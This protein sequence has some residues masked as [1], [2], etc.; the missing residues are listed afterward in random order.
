MHPFYVCLFDIS[1]VVQLWHLSPDT[2]T[3]SAASSSLSPVRTFWAHSMAVLS[4]DWSEGEAHS[5]L[6]GCL[7]GAVRWWDVK[8]TRS[9]LL[10]LAGMLSSLSLSSFSF[11]L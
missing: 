1:G 2:D 3:D 8:D 6:T 7:N 5:L 11:L 10:T 9:P 4:L